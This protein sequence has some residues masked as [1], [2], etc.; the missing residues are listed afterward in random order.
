MMMMKYYYCR[1]SSCCSSSN[2]GGFRFGG[3]GYRWLRT[4]LV[5]VEGVLFLQLSFPVPV[6]IDSGSIDWVEEDVFGD[7]RLA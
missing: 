1:C 6:T 4:P 2:F 5:V 3:L 7:V